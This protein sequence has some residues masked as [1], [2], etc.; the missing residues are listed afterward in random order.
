M[1]KSFNFTVLF[2]YQ[3]R[4][5]TQ[6]TIRKW[7]TSCPSSSQTWDN[8]KAFWDKIPIINSFCANTCCWLMNSLTVVWTLSIFSLAMS[9]LNDK[10]WI[11]VIKSMFDN[12]RFKKQFHFIKRW[13]WFNSIFKFSCHLWKL[14]PNI[15]HLNRGVCVNLT[16]SRDREYGELRRRMAILGVIFINKLYS[17][18][19]RSF[20]SKEIRAPTDFRHWENSANETDTDKLSAD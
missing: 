8:L 17:A 11:N 10:S 9:L 5:V 7:F 14:K 1:V 15:K 4:D 19:K 12:L 13:L 16:C 2:A 20:L 3:I 6:L 18:Q